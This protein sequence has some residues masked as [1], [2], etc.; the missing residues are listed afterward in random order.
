MTI[1]E[2]FVYFMIILAAL[3]LIP[4]VLAIYRSWDYKRQISGKRKIRTLRDGEKLPE[5]AK[6][7]KRDEEMDFEFSTTGTRMKSWHNF[8]L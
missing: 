3:I 4:V 1:N 5:E 6:Y 2:A 8:H 7:T